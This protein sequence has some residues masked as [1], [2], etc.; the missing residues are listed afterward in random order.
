MT[1]IHHINLYNI[2]NDFHEFLIEK[3]IEI[4]I[5][6]TKIIISDEWKFLNFRRTFGYEL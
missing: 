4:I 1:Y 2:L 5:F 6:E 3:V